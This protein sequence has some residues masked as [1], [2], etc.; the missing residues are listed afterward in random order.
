MIEPIVRALRDTGTFGLVEVARPE[1]MKFEAGSLRAVREEYERVKDER[2]VRLH[3]DHAPVIDEDGQRVNFRAIIEQA[4]E[5]GYDSVQIDGSRLPLE[6]NIAATKQMAELAHA[7]GIPIEGELG[8]VLGHEPGPLPSY[9]ELWT[10]GKGFTDPDEAGRFVQETGVDWL[11]VAIGNIHGAI[12]GAARLARKLEA[13]LNIKR[14]ERIRQTTGIPLVLHGGSGVQK[15]SLM[16]AIKH[17]IVKVNVGTTTRQAYERGKQESIAAA[18][19]A[20]Y[21][22]VVRLITE[23]FEAAGSAAHINPE[24]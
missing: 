8:S 20:V 22:A 2:F 21:E 24:I 1:W 16:A 11:A 12:S 7:A 13:R 3:L 17:G 23:E 4:I 18:Q 5:L 9:E 10:T 15:E 19:R 14:L 6:E